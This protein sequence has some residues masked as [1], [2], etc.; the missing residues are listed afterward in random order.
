MKDKEGNQTATATGF[1]N[2]MEGPMMGRE[3]REQEEEEEQ[4]KKGRKGRRG[5]EREDSR[6]IEQEE[7]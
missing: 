2:R 6:R 3:G 7:N 4:N 5:R 1:E